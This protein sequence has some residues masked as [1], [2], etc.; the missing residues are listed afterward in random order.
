MS[1]QPT[2]TATPSGVQVVAAGPAGPPGP[3]GTGLGPLTADAD[4]PVVLLDMAL[5]TRHQVTLGGNRT[6]ATAN[7]AANPVFMVILIQDSQ[8]SRTVSW[9]PGIRWPGGAVPGLTTTPGKADVFSFI[10]LGTGSYL[11]FTAG[12]N[13]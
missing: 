11:G 10:R 1:Q 8:G 5:T 13:L 6:L 4:Q 3:P 12:Q 7:D 9:W 2:V